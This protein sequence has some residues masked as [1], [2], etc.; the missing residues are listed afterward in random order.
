MVDHEILASRIA[1]CFPCRQVA[2]H[3]GEYAGEKVSVSDLVSSLEYSMVSRAA[4]ELYAVNHGFDAM[5]AILKLDGDSYYQMNIIDY[6]VGNTDRHWENW[7]LLVDN[8]DNRPVCLYPLMDFN[9]SFHSYDT[10][11][12]ANCLTARIRTMTQ[13]EAA[14][15]AVH[16]IGLPLKSRPDPL[17][18]A[19]REAEWEMFRKRMDIL[20]EMVPDIIQI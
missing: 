4:Y 19:G 8:R 18:F 12:G 3:E 17:W 10:V 20:R 13:R 15:E 5:E 7:G 6:L 14:V 9:Q 2:Y 16:R 1:G 11:D